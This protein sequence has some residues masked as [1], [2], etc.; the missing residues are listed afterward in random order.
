MKVVVLSI[1]ILFIAGCTTAP[2][3]GRSQIKLWFLN[4]L[5]ELN[6]FSSY[7]AV[8]SEETLSTN[9]VQTAQLKDVGNRIA[10]AV[11][12]YLQQEQLLYLV[13]GFQWEFNL[14]ESDIPNAWCMP[15]GKVA[16]YTGI[17]PY[18][19]DEDGM[20]VVMGHEIAH[21]VMGHSSE[22]VSHALL[23]QWWDTAFEHNA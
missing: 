20:A 18:T 4:E 14:I 6:H 23:Q 12:L 19:Q 10:R 11:E 1:A 7:Q 17:L 15:G 9:A 3:S 22:R 2:F 21:A 8:I 13:D 5:L 16:F